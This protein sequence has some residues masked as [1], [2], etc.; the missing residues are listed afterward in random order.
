MRARPV[1]FELPDDLL[2]RMLDFV[3]HVLS[4]LAQ[5]LE[6]AGTNPALGK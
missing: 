2:E 1:Y 4:H 5:L 3:L 6:G